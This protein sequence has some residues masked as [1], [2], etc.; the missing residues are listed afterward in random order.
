M[1]E[2]IYGLLANLDPV[3]RH[4]TRFAIV[5]LLLFSGPQSEGD[6]ARKLRLQWG[7]LTTHLR[8]LREAGYVEV[9]KDITFRGP[10][11]YV[12]LTDKGIWAYNTYMETLNRIV[13]LARRIQTQ[14]KR[15][16][17]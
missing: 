1:S 17:E 7:P 10:R 6:I 11:T 9:R 4:P 14:D 13:S 15:V 12:R 3:L 16:K 5:T 8:R 2:D